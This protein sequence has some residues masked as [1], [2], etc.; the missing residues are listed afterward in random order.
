MLRWWD[1]EAWSETEFKLAKSVVS[2]AAATDWMR[3]P[4][5]RRGSLTNVVVCSAIVIGFVTFAS[6]GYPAAW[7]GLVVGL[8]LECCF[9]AVAVTVRRGRLPRQVEQMVLAFTPR[10]LRPR[11]VAGR[12]LGETKYP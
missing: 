3:G 1:G 5:G 4:L 8:P 6:A 10:K 11:S 12:D 9:I 7:L 2:P